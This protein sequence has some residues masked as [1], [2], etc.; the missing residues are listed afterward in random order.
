MDKL[1]ISDGQRDQIYS[2]VESKT[3]HGDIYFPD[4]VDPVARNCFLYAS[5]LARTDSTIDPVVCELGGLLHDIGYSRDFEPE[6]RDHVLKGTRMAPGILDCLGIEGD[7]R[8]MIVDTIWTHDGNLD[9]SAYGNPAPSNNRIVNDVDAMQLFDWNLASL[10]QFSL[11]LQPGR[12]ISD[13]ATELLEH[14]DQTMPY[15]SMDFFQ[16]LARP[17]YEARRK[18]LEAFI[19]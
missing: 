10:F 19:E 7:Y 17:K 2:E 18:E 12:P 15:I 6:E 8:D 1:Q 16:K 4:H 13:V 14:V 9:R 11:R 3:S 5:H